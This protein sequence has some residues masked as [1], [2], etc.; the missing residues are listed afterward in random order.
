[1]R[2]LSAVIFDQ[3]HEDIKTAVLGN[4]GTHICFRIGTT[5]AEIL[6]KEFYPIFTKSELVSLPQFYMYIKL[7]IDGR[8]SE[9]FSGRISKIS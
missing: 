2:I 1:M 7:Q 5:D 8:V 6:E 4:I 3:L 9:R